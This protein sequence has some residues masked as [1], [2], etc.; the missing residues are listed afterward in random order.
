MPRLTRRTLPGTDL[1]LSVVG[2]GCW[3]IGGLWWG[4]DVRDE[5][6][7]AAI[8]AAIEG[9]I[10][11]FDTAP[12]YGRGHADELL[13]ATLGAR[14]HEV[15]IATKVGV[16]IEGADGHA[17]SD[18]S[19]AHVVAD[20]EASLRRL[21]L[22]TIPLLQVHWPCERGTPL[23]ATLETLVRLQ[24]QGKIRHFGLCNYG[25]EPL[26]RAL[27][28]A[29]LASLQT[30][31]SMVRREFDHGLR[32]VVAPAPDAARLG[33]LAYEV[34]A[35]GLLTG[36]FTTRPS[37]PD[38]D[39][40]SRDDRFAEPGFSKVQRLVQALRIVGGR[41]GMPPA[42]L[43]IGWALTR[44][45]ISAAIVGA[46]RPDQVREHLRAAELLG[47]RKVWEALAPHVE[48]VRI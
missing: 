12:L 5:D 35:R 11:W 27:E 16:R 7:T 21:G 24:E 41:L 40:R 10:N 1:E 9:G 29:P 39:L 26:A 14:R 28:L 34:L 2:L 48:H 45:G 19:P 32:Q 23:E 18:L 46:K 38:T 15:I 25:P 44:P 17:H 37:F 47:R 8:E 30:P 22:D 6:S 20:T 43:A 13:A 36:K 3:A 33:V 31:Y 4:D 42:A